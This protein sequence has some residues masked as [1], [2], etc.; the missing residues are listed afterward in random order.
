MAWRIIAVCLLLV[1]V[2]GGASANAAPA[3]RTYVTNDCT[4]VR[5]EPRAIMFTCADGN[6]YARRLAWGSW[7]RFRAV[8]EGAIH[9]NDCE[10]SC[11]GGTFHMRRGRVVL[12]HRRWC[13][14]VHRYLFRRVMIRFR[15]PLLGDERVSWPLACP[16]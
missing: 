6:F 3:R 10:P 2:A 16:L 5:V 7:H 13:D 12:T 1:C 14:D 11:A 8:G 15:R 9:R 4:G